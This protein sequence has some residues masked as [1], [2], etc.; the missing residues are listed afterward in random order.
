MRATTFEPADGGQKLMLLATPIKPRPLDGYC[1]ENYAGHFAAR[2]AERARRRGPEYNPVSHWQ[3]NEVML[4]KC[5][6]QRLA[7][8]PMIANAGV[9]SLLLEGLGP[10]RDQFEMFAYATSSALHLAHRR[11]GGNHRPGETRHVSRARSSLLPAAFQQRDRPGQSRGERRHGH[12][13]GA[14][15]L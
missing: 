3:A 15:L 13:T 8:Y 1:I 12:H 7:A 11:P 9:K 6:Q 4:M 10:I 5:A 14:G 2:A